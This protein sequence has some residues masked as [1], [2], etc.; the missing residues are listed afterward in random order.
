MSS[1]KLL[2]SSFIV[3][4]KHNFKKLKIQFKRSR[5]M[6]KIESIEAT[7]VVKTDN[8]LGECPLWSGNEVLWV[9]IDGKKK[10]W[11][12]SYNADVCVFP[13]SNYQ[14][15][16]RHCPETEETRTYLLPERPGSFAMTS[17]DRLIFAFEKG[18]AF[19]K[20]RYLFYGKNC[21]FRTRY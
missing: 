5:S 3:I 11:V 12:T 9:D 10:F 21:R 6:E 14:T 8:I 15:T 1:L 13:L 18:L 20:P 17:D 2:L 19:Y 7:L 4:S 16:H